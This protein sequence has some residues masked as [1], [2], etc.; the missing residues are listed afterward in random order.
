MRGSVVSASNSPE[1]I[2][3][4]ARV[5]A[6]RAL[7]RALERKLISPA[8]ACSS[9]PTCRTRVAGS[10]ATRPPRRW[11]ISP[12]VNA[13]CMT[14]FRGRLAVQ[15][16]DHLVGDVDARAREHGVLE[17]DVE[18][19]LLGDLADDAVGLLHHLRQLLVAPLVEVLAE[20]ALLALELAVEVAELALLAAALRVAHGHGVL[21]QVVLHLLQLAGDLGEL[22]VALLE[23]RFDLLLR[24][25]RRNRVAQD[26][27]GVDEAELAALRPGRRSGDGQCCGEKDCSHR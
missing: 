11:A 8:C 15:R 25:L 1:R 5:A 2:T 10:P 17:D 6:R 22:L 20:L 3:A 26:A 12:S 19:L 13:P 24:A 7:N 27:L 16:L 14:L 4:D 21:V 18:L 9:E 23:F